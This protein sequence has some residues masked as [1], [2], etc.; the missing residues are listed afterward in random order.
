MRLA[1]YVRQ[2]PPESGFEPG[3]AQWE[4]IRRWADDRGELLVAVCQD[5][6]A[7]RSGDPV[8]GLRALLALLDGGA[9]DTV[10]I[11]SLAVLG[12]VADQ[13]LT[14]AEVRRRHAFMVS[15]DPG[16]G[17]ALEGEDETGER[18]SMRRLLDAAE[19]RRLGSTTI[20]EGGR[21]IT[22]LSAS[23]PARARHPS[24]RRWEG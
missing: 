23:P 20:D 12:D 2:L 13:E 1:G 15:A 16:D 21:W 7:P 19:T 24:R 5:D 18:K 9:A 3:F 8:A 17:S 6:A 4:R 22:D 11:A 14:L 10:V